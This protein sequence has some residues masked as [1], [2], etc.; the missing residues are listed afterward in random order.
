MAKFS[1]EVL[2]SEVQ[3][4]PP[5]WKED[6]VYFRRRDLTDKLWEE[7]AAACH[8]ENP[9]RTS[10]FID[11]V[12]T[13]SSFPHQKVVFI[14]TIFEEQSVSNTAKFLDWCHLFN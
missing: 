7:V 3:T 14:I 9:V 10:N 13:I 12:N 5:L 11:W 8:M 1:K 4:R 2:I 6:D